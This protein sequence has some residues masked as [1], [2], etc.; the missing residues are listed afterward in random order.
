MIPVLHSSLYP[1]LLPYNL[2]LPF[3][4]I[5]GLAMLLA[6]TNGML[7]NR[8]Q[9]E[10][11]NT[12]AWLGLLILAPLPWSWEL[13][14]ASPREDGTVETHWGNQHIPA[15]AILDETMCSWPPRYFG[16]AQPRASESSPIRRTP[17]I[18]GSMLFQFG[19]LL[20]GYHLSNR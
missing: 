15:E 20:G 16:W 12:L 19:S 1:W 7:A 6:L 2:A 4:L 13:A 10:A 11:H 9:V 8:I 14:W 3:H 18:C 5:L 17:H